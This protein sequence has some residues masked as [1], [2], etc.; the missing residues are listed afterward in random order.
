VLPPGP[1]NAVVTVISEIARTPGL[2]GV[3]TGTRIAGRLFDDPTVAPV[4]AELER[5]ALPVF[6]HPHYG[7]IDGPTIST[8]KLQVAVGYPVETTMALGRLIDAGITER[9]PR[10]RLLASH[11]GGALLSLIAR[12]QPSGGSAKAPLDRFAVDAV[13]FDSSVMSGLVERL[14]PDRVLFGTDHPFGRLE[15]VTAALESLD[16]ADRAQVEASA[17]CAFFGLVD[18]NADSSG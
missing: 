2:V 5:T 11:G 9:H 7:V 10:L 14:G 17:A 4:W 16:D 13:V 12:L 3:I 8:R 6:V 15:P 1:V 18:E